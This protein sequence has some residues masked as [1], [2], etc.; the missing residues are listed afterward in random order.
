ME[1]K[2]IVN[3]PFQSN[4]YVVYGA[5][6]DEALIIDPAG[7]VTALLSYIEERKLRTKYVLLTHEHFDH[8]TGTVSIKTSYPDALIAC[9]STCAYRI[10][11]PKL[12]L[13]V[14]KG[15]P[16]ISAEADILLDGNGDLNWIYPISFLGWGGHSPGGMIFNVDGHLFCGD[17][18]IKNIKT[19]TNLPG[20][21]KEQVRKCFDFLKTTFSPE[22]T[23]H[24][25]HGDTMCLRELS[26]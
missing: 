8:I 16:Y 24:P 7:D 11:D 6:A 23:L 18:F 1:I 9:S 4:T 17:Q 14:Y 20:G 15:T 26:W 13:S 12:N 5:N 3:E 22:T 10:T 2:R 19:V 21:D 25:G